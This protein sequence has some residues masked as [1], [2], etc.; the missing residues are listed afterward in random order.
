MQ[1]PDNE[2]QKYQI[3]L[4]KKIILGYVVSIISAI[5]VC[6]TTWELT[7]FLRSGYNLFGPA[8][9]FLV[10]VAS[11]GLTTTAVVSICTGLSY[12]RKTKLKIANNLGPAQT[13]DD[14]ADT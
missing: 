3:Y 5:L 6:L 4:K 1:V 13:S 2:T 12:C 10:L 11:V 7:V 8:I 14:T 9:T